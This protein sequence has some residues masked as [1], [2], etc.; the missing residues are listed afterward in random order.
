LTD[1]TKLEKFDV[2]KMHSIYDEWP[3]M[4]RDS[5]EYDHNLEEFNKISHIVF[6]GM[7]GSGAIGDIFKSILSRTKIHVTVVKGYI[8]PSTVNNETLVIPISISGNTVETLASLK[9]AIKLNAKILAFSSGGKMKDFCK[10]NNIQ[11]KEIAMIHSPRSSFVIFLFSM[12]KILKLILPIKESDVIEAIESMEKIKKN[13]YYQNMTKQNLALQ[14]AQSITKIPL[15]Y[16]PYGLES[17]AIRFKN[18]LQE[19]AKI[20]AFAEDV[21]EECHNGIVSWEKKSNFIPILIQGSDDH[22]KTKERW[23]ILKKYFET[24]SIQY[25]EI[26]SVQGGILS[27]IINLIYL[28][29]YTSIYLA[30]LSKT[31]PTPVKS[32]EFIKKNLT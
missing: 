7:G 3:K 30:L 22:I 19:N 10:K 13:I 32:I 6:I 1:Y 23:I 25:L 18:C 16:Y 29:D 8:I 14:L 12:L 17:A 26:K 15:I 11:H 27:K 28:L 9:S 20:H 24:N 5:Y 2:S 21:I 4:A 31:D